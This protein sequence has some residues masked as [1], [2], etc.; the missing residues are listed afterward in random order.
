MTRLTIDDP[1]SRVLNEPVGNPRFDHYFF[2]G[3]GT[4][5][6]VGR[7]LE[8]PGIACHEPGRQKSEDL[9]EGEVPRHHCQ[10]DS[11]RLVVEVTL[12]AFGRDENVGQHAFGLVGV[13]VAD[14]GA[15]LDLGPAGGHRL[16]H[17]DRHQAGEFVLPCFEAFRCRRE[18]PS[19]RS[20]NGT[21][22]QSR[23]ARWAAT[24]RPSTSSQ[25]YS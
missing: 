21:V 23:K 1:I 17:L 12:G 9:P 3:E 22:R 11:E 10:D 24:R 16:S 2:D 15:L 20:E 19:A 7:V 5:G 8:D 13:V 25:L 18:A 6:D 4:A 14:P